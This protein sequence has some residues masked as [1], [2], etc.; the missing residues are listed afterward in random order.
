MA[1]PFV[2]RKN[3]EPVA[4][5][6][7]RLF[8]LALA[9]FVVFAMGAGQVTALGVYPRG[10]TGTDVSWPNCQASPAGNNA[11]GIVGMTGGLNFKPNPCL[12]LET[13][14]F[15]SPDLYMNTG[16]PG[17]EAARQYSAYPRRCRP[18]DEMC[19]AYNYGFNAAAYALLYAAS[20][21]V[22]ASTWW[23]DVETENSW[24]DNLQANRMALQGT[25]DAIKHGTLFP[26]IGVYATQ[27][28]WEQITGGWKNGL[29]NWVGTDS[30]NRN[31]AI[32][33]CHGNDFTAGGTQLTQY[34]LKLDHD[35]ARGKLPSRKLF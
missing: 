6:Q 31:D 19:L 22:H 21:T 3:R 11:F 23:L 27:L 9:V 7:A 26:T 10:A 14:W 24:S 2:L 13:R 30:A 29:P 33:A 8:G 1:L 25:I 34:V 5:R 17:L 16:Y 32:A 18:A 12:Y 28:Q 4:P 20:Q 15:V 35:Y